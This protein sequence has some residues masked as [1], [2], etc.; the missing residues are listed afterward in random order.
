LSLA[1][2]DPF[3]AVEAVEAVETV[4]TVES[5]QTLEALLFLLASFFFLPALAP[6]GAHC[7]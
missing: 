2:R 5:V 4:E 6:E 3:E 1:S 7:G